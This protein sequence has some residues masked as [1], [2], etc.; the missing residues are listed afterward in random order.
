MK[1]EAY[2]PARQQSALMAR[3]RRANTAPELAVRRSAHRLGY[4][5]RLHRKDLPG[6]PDIVFPKARKVIFVHG[7]FWHRHAGCGAA[8]MPKTRSD[9]WQEKFIANIKRD[10]QKETELRNLGWQ[11]L[12]IWE[13][14]THDAVTLRNIL[15]EFLAQ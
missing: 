15:S 6:T 4:R 8:S 13:C 12:V 14:Q 5:F 7:C 9:F 3:V 2:I 1:G 10:G 11:S